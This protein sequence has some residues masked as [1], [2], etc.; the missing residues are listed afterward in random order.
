MA[1]SPKTPPTWASLYGEP[2]GTRR[3]ALL[4]AGTWS[5]RLQQ[6]NGGQDVVVLPLARGLAALDAIQVPIGDGYALFADYLHGKLLT[7]LSPG[8]AHLWADVPDARV[9]PIGGWVVVPTPGSIGSYAASWLSL[10]PPHP[11]PSWEDQVEG[12]DGADET[13]A[14]PHPG[15][16]HP[17]MSAGA[18]DPQQLFEAFTDSSAQS[19]AAAH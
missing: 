3:D 6:H 4:A 12:E 11:C 19:S 2:R 8:W 1:K 18:L 13:L 9:V 16:P 5:T 15:S 17:S 14:G 10:P 7:L